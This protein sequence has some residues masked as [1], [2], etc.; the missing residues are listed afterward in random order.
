VI[1]ELVDVAHFIANCLVALDV[2]DAEWEA[3]YQAKQ[4]VNRQRARDG[5]SARKD[6][7]A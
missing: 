3:A 2:S 5:Y 4:Q 1:E 6:G 7:Q